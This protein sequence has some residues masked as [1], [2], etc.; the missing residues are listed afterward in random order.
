MVKSQTNQQFLNE[1]IDGIYSL[2]AMNQIFYVVK[3]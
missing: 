1:I 3:T 2:N